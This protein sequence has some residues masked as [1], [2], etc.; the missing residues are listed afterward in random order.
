MSERLWNFIFDI[1]DI[2]I[3]GLASI[4]LILRIAIPILIV[5]LLIKLI[6]FTKRK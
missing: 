2:V 4:I 1:T 6:K 5:V 3:Y